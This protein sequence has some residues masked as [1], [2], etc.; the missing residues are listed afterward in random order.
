MQGS[1]TILHEHNHTP[2]DLANVCRELDDIYR[3][4]EIADKEADR[5]HRCYDDLEETSKRD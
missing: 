3:K 1:W 4:Y 5:M 2:E